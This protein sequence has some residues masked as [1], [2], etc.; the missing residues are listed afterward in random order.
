MPRVLR[1]IIEGAVKLQ[2]D[3]QLIDTSNDRD[4]FTAVR[5]SAPDVVILTEQTP[6]QASS[7][8]QLLF[9]NPDLKMFVVTD[10]GHEAHFLEFHR[11]PVTQMSPRTLLAAIRSAVA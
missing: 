9:E 2:S 1:D 5:R 7:H 3:M 11:I 6:K 10:D 8:Q 4:L